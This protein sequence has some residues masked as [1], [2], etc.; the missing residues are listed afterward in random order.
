MQYRFSKIDESHEYVYEE[1]VH[2]AVELLDCGARRLRLA[3]SEIDTS[4]ERTGRGRALLKWHIYLAVLSVDYIEAVGNLALTGLA[5]PMQTA[6]S[7]HFRI[8]HE[9]TL[10]CGKPEDRT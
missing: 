4:G 5:R 10:L 1:L 2:L 3:I 6:E 7:Q 8:S 9:G